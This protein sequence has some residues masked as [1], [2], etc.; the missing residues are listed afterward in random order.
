MFEFVQILFMKVGEGSGEDEIWV[1]CNTK[2]LLKNSYT[3]PLI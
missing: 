2:H 1:K 3:N